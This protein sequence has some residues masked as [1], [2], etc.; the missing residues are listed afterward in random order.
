M[1]HLL[2]LEA[3]LFFFIPKTKTLNSNT[4]SKYRLEKTLSLL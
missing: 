3:G 2:L 4:L 1:K